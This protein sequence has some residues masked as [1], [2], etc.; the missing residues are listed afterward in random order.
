MLA[1]RARVCGHRLEFIITAMIPENK[2]GAPKTIEV[3]T[4]PPSRH[5]ILM[6][7][8]DDHEVSYSAE[9]GGL[10]TGLKF[11]DLESGK[12]VDILY[13]DEATFLDDSANVK[14]GIPTMFPIV[15][16]DQKGVGTLYKD[17]YGCVK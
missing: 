10:I 12:L 14:G 8:E 6:V 16:R 1:L 3:P 9:H 11:R 13:F 5:E 2:L 15:G 7:K 17:G 4:G